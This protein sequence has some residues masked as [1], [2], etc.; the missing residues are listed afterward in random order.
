MKQLQTINTIKTFLPSVIGLDFS[1][2]YGSFGRNEG[3]ANSDIDIQLIV[4]SNFNTKAF[5]EQLSDLF[6]NEA[7]HIYEVALR[8]KVVVYFQQQPK[9]EF[10]VVY[11]LNDINRNYLGSEI[12]NAENTILYEN[13]SCKIDIRTYLEGII[14]DKKSKVVDNI[15]EK[16]ITDLVDKFMYEFENC[17]TMHRRS[18]SFQFYFFYNIA[19]HLCVQLN[20][21]SKGHSKYLFLPK[22][23]ATQFLD[24]DEKAIF[25]SIKGTLFLPEANVQKRNL[26]NFFYL[27]I[28]TLLDS[29]KQEK[30]KKILEWIYERDFY[31]NFRDVSSFNPKIK[32]GILYRTA[33]LSLCQH[34]NRLNQ[35]LEKHKI[36]SIIDLR[37]TREVDELPYQT[38][39]LNSV[40]YTHAPFDPWNQP[41]WFKALEIGGSNADIAYSF[42]SIACN[43]QV[44]QVMEEII[45]HK[46]G[47]I[48]I[49]CYAGK[50]RTGIIIS[51]LHLLVDTP[52]ELVYAD[53]LASESDTI[54]ER[55]DILLNI[56]NQKGGIVSYL[57]GCGLTA[58][59]IDELKLKIMYGN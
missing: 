38:D 40:K 50:D 47:A 17:S 31:W 30:I 14:S 49:H 33:T 2:L 24:K 26:L 42:F 57:L 51:L 36:K 19:L 15:L 29:E 54:A 37:A 1:L 11:N 21:I 20:Y 16:Q 9:I 53:Y 58:S 48:A 5:I 52:L 18:D 32:P 59:Q 41:D 46:E 7:V 6:K 27:S 22:N 45:N 10:G 3:K 34:E 25:Q 44:K 39:I 56:I 13:P 35:L 23:V 43:E 55:L 28:K 12:S 8:N 4:N